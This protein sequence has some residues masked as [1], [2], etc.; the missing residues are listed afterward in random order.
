MKHVAFQVHATTSGSTEPHAVLLDGGIARS[1]PFQ[2]LAAVFLG[3]AAMG[4]GLV[5]AGQISDPHLT[6]VASALGG[7]IGVLGAAAAFGFR[8]FGKVVAFLLLAYVI[9]LV[10]GLAHY[11]IV[12]DPSY[13]QHPG[14]YEYLSE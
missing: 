3:L 6:L 11:L 9:R 12:M 4:T 1:A 13:F 5:V 10:L 14:S 7:F 2:G 8:P